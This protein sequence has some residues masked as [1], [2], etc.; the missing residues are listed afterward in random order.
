MDCKN[1]VGQ[2]SASFDE[3]MTMLCKTAKVPCIVCGHFDSELKALR[4]IRAARI[5]EFGSVSTA[6]LVNLATA[7]L[8]VFAALRS[9]PVLPAGLS[10]DQS[11][12]GRFP[13]WTRQGGCILGVGKPVS[14]LY[15]II[16]CLRPEDDRL[17]PDL[18][19]LLGIGLAHVA[20]ALAQQ[21]Y[22]RP[23]WPEGLAETTLRM[24]A[25]GYFVVNAQAEV[26]HDGR[27]DEC[28]PDQPWLVANGRLS[29]RVEAER[30]ALHAAIADATSEGLAASIISVSHGDG[31]SRMAAVAPLGRGDRGLALVLFE[32]RRTNHSALRDHFFRAYA[33]TRAESLTAQEVLNGRSPNE[34]AEVMGLSVATVRSYLK[35]VLA[36]TG[37]HRQSE[38]ISLYYSSILPVGA[39]IAR[40]EARRPA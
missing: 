36:K 6:E 32:S 29:L 17:R 27:G 23:V 18:H 33:L 10:P 24:L 38:L 2:D 20:Q 5:A 15:P 30:A 3:F 35:Q 37:T 4:N 1:N 13:V 31:P 40:A 26:V 7:R 22:A 12:A 21:V 28:G 11:D 9:K 14:R 25:I 8:S 19:E 16:A 39:T 34:M